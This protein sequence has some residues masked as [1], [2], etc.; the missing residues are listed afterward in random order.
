LPFD[1]PDAAR[2]ERLFAP[3]FAVLVVLVFDD[4][5]VA[6]SKP[7]LTGLYFVKACAFQPVGH[8]H[9]AVSSGVSPIFPQRF[10][11]H[12]D[13]TNRRNAAS[14]MPFANSEISS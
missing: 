10:F 14:A 9:H 12:A 8:S 3:A 2:V 13:F 6:T 5:R 4:L 1:G 11:V 7:P